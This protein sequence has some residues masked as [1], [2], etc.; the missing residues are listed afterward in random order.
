MFL[1]IF[2]DT[3]AYQNQNLPVYGT[4]LIIR[5]DMQ[6]VQQRIFYSDSQ[7]S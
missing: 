4:G 6:L 2:S 7:T 5:H 3:F 1:F